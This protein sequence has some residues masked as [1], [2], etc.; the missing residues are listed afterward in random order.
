MGGDRDRVSQLAS[1]GSTSPVEQLEQWVDRSM[2]LGPRRRAVAAFVEGFELGER[3]VGLGVQ[4]IV[5]GWARHEATVRRR[6]D[7]PSVGCQ[8]S[9]AASETRSWSDATKGELP[10]LRRSPFQSKRD[11]N[12]HLPLSQRGALSVELLAT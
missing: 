11:S 6:R 5:T 9:P 1:D 3:L 10:V 8:P 12:P 7:T 4:L 2:H